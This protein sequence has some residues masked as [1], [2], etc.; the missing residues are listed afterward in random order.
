M[1]LGI[2]GF[3][4][5]YTRSP[6]LHAG[7]LRAARLH[8]Q[9]DVLPF[10]PSRGKKAFFSFLD[11]LAR[12]GYVGLNVTIPL[13]E[14]AYEYA[15]RR[16]GTTAGFHGRC[17]KAVRAANTLVFRKQGAQCANTDAYGLWS[18]AGAWLGLE[19]A[20][21]TYDVIVV[22]TGGSARG[23]VA[24]VVARHPA[25]RYVY[26]VAV[27]GRTPAKVR[28]VRALIPSSHR[29]AKKVG[30]RVLVFWCLPPLSKTAAKKEWEKI[31][32]LIGDRQVFL[33][34]LNYGDRAESTA[35]LVARRRRKTGAGMLREQAR[36]SF[37]LW[38]GLGARRAR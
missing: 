12:D 8:G 17:A 13:K 35:K 11:G 2:T 25:A 15:S 4:L 5:T 3:P 38:A 22:G 24:G 18:D 6:R 32:G 28:A 34:D 30:E 21:S 26:N 20:S 10:D 9:Y 23:A 29:A 37:E 16:G 31:A 7:F 14:W 1:R 27:V 36:C 19:T 33:Y